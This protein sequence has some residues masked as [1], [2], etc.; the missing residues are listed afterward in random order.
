MA[1]ASR[2]I[3]INAPIEKVFDIVTD[4][5]K[6]PEFVPDLAGIKVK[7]KNGNVAEVTFTINVMMKISYT[8]RL[9]ETRP[10]KVDWTLVDGQ[11]MKT[12]EGGWLLEDQSG[13]TK[14]TYT[15]DVGLK[16][17]VPKSVVNTLV[18][19]NLPK[20]LEAFKRRAEG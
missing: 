6:Y 1:G 2:S 3:V 9:V 8:L 11:M 17:L 4:F 16:G 15:V 19:V 18:D 20:M 10:T 13:K 14:A 12:N 5:D 7:S